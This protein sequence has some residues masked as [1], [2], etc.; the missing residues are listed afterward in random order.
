MNVSLQHTAAALL[1]LGAAMIVSASSA[2]AT[3][4]VGRDTATVV[5]RYSAMDQGRGYKKKPSA[6]YYSKKDYKKK[7]Y[8][9]KDY[10]KDDYYHKNKNDIAHKGECGV[11]IYYY[12]F[13][14][15]RLLTT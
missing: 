5:D 15:R 4:V 3:S 14:P 13:S 9:K 8:Y 1:L 12:I 7:E 6:S 11:N 10:K 2:S